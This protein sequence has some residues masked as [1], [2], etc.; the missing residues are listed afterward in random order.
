MKDIN[1]RLAFY[2]LLLP[3]V[4]LSQQYSINCPVAFHTT[5]TG[6]VTD[7]TYQISVTPS[8]NCNSYRIEIPSHGIDINTSSTELF[9]I[10]R[11]R[12]KVLVRVTNNCDNSINEKYIIAKK[13]DDE[14]FGTS[15]YILTGYVVLIGNSI[16]AGAT[17]SNRTNIF[18]TFFGWDGSYVDVDDWAGYM[19]D[20]YNL[21]VYNMG[22]GG[23]TSTQ[24]LAR[25]GRD[26]LGQT[27]AVGDGNPDTTIGTV[28]STLPSLIWIHVG[29]ND[30]ALATTVSTIESNIES[31]VSQ[32]DAL[33]VK[34]LINNVGATDI[35]PV[36][37]SKI[38]AI[39]EVNK[40][41]HSGYLQ[42]QYD[43]VVKNFNEWS[44]GYNCSDG[45]AH[46]NYFSDGIHPTKNGYQYY[47]EKFISAKF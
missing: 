35:F 13:W 42:N 14:T 1:M 26:A 24:V 21:R 5:E 38:D 11:Q 27:V 10:E 39:Y 15:P 20:D 23:Q 36:G 29:I 33:G 19:A 47:Y 46:P 43:V 40:W 9:D 45:E 3:I 37:S 18:P 7:T 12:G 25:F 28:E 2:I 31:M 32:A 41:L 22:W 34:V 17:S 16:S 4:C 8:G 30:I 44:R 6:S